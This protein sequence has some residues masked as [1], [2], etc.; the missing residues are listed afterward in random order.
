MP[1]EKDATP[2]V[3]WGFRATGRPKGW[4]A[5]PIRAVGDDGTV[6]MLTGIVDVDGN[7]VS[8]ATDVTVVEALSG[9]TKRLDTLIALLQAVLE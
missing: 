1:I 2:A 7:V 8:P 9:L 3:N 6:Y 4:V 5:D